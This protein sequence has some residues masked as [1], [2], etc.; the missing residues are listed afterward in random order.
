MNK[1]QSIY[2]DALESQVSKFDVE[3]SKR[4][5]KEE[6]IDK[7]IKILIDMG[8]VHEIHGSTKSK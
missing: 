3:K 6:R 5:K 7:N 2:R 1:W 4:E 8:C